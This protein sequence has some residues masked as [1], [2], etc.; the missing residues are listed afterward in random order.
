M[1]SVFG[2]P[3]VAIFLT[4]LASLLTGGAF[5]LRETHTRAQAYVI[6]AGLYGSQGFF[7][8]LRSCRGGG[9]A[10]G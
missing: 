6:I 4:L 5:S 9:I 2:V 8:L 1:H 10:G 3:E 7:A